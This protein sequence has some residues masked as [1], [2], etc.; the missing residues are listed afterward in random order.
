MTDVTQDSGNT[1]SSKTA[2]GKA[3]EGR[4]DDFIHLFLFVGGTVLLGGT[5]LDG[6]TPVGGRV[7][8]AVLCLGGLLG[9]WQ[10]VR[11]RFLP[12]LMPA[13]RERGGRSLRRLRRLHTAVILGSSLG[14]AG[15]AVGYLVMAPHHPPR[16]LDRV[17]LVGY[18]LVLAAM[19]DFLKDREPERV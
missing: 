16:W 12:G 4:K 13:R 1:G 9:I 11:R 19:A 3:G 7:A 14:F 10:R 18:F 5:V 15:Y 8:A 6:H 2:S 17:V